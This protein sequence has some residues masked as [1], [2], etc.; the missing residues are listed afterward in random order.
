LSSAKFYFTEQFSRN[1]ANL[2][3]VV[4]STPFDARVLVHLLGR[5]AEVL[6]ERHLLAAPEDVDASLVAA[7]DDK[8]ATR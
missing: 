1:F 5:W 4:L 6:L 7:G 8:A 3:R 2:R